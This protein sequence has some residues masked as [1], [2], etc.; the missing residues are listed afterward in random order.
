MTTSTLTGLATALR[1]G[2]DTTLSGAD[3]RLAADALTLAAAWLDNRPRDLAVAAIAL[4][5]RLDA[6]TAADDAVKFIL[7]AGAL[8]GVRPRPV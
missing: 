8:A 2:H 6:S 5:K 1:H 3:A 7:D 4:N